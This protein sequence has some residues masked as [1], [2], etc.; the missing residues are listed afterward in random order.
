MECLKKTTAIICLVFIVS[1]SGPQTQVRQP[2]SGITLDE[3]E[4]LKIEWKDDIPQK[5][6]SGRGQVFY[7]VRS[8]DT[9]FGISVKFGISVD[10][11]MKL[12]GLRSN[13]IR[14]GMKL[15]LKQ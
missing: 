4:I 13:E 9:L 3:I 11:I 6:V 2:V 7:T 15:R 5:T 1:C 14:P 8:G 10:A 12:N